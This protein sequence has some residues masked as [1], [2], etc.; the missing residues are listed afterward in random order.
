MKWNDK[1]GEGIILDQEQKKS[2]LVV[3]DDISKS[4]QNYKTLQKFAFVEFFATDEVDSVSHLRMAKN[5]TGMHGTYVKPSQQ[6]TE[7]MLRKGGFPKRWAD[8]PE[9]YKDIKK[10]GEFYMSKR[11]KC[12]WTD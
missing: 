4:Y 9:D 3:R 6:Y 5:I 10:T 11:W 8:D 1:A 12:G 7:L 2:Y